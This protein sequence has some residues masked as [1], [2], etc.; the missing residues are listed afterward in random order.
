MLGGHTVLGG[1]TNHGPH[2]CKAYALPFSHLPGPLPAFFLLR[3]RIVSLSK[4]TRP[5]YS[6][7][8][9]HWLPSLESYFHRSRLAGEPGTGPKKEAQEALSST[10]V[11]KELQTSHSTWPLPASASQAFDFQPF[12]C[13]AFPCLFQMCW[14]AEG[15]GE[16]PSH[17]HPLS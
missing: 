4:S 10:T 6:G 16:A 12:A 11:P 14:K 1:R 8:V 15:G 2:T 17:P 13:R 9:D 5:K 7:G 3:W